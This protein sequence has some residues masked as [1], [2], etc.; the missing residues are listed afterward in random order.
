MKFIFPQNY[1]LKLKLFGILDYG[2]AIFDLIWCLLIFFILQLTFHS[3][4]IS[5]IF[6]I[7]LSIPVLIFSVVGFNGENMGTILKYMLIYLISPKF[8]V[9]NKNTF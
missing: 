1:N 8:Y 5:I 4:K 2:T 9:F 6:S 7:V 3:I